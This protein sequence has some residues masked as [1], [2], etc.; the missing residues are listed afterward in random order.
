MFQPIC[1]AIAMQKESTF[2]AAI[3]AAAATATAMLPGTATSI[4]GTTA[5]S[6]ADTDTIN[7]TLISC[8]QWG[9]V[10]PG[11]VEPMLATP[12]SSLPT[13]FSNQQV[14]TSTNTSSIGFLGLPTQQQQT[15]QASA[16]DTVYSL[17]QAPAAAVSGWI[18]PTAESKEDTHP[19]STSG[20]VTSARVWSQTHHRH[21]QLLVYCH[22]A[23]L[24]C[25]LLDAWCDNRHPNFQQV[26]S[27]ITKVRCPPDSRLTQGS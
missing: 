5:T 6:A 12:S 2:K 27:A 18:C 14:S 4:V 1:F 11:N 25:M 16:I 23:V 7:Q 10:Q 13:P 22:G 3:V 21:M 19:A 8:S 9:V 17:S 26:L 20:C 15:I 24:V